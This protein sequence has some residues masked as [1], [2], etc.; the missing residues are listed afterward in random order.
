MPEKIQTLQGP[1]C[2]RLVSR[3]AEAASAA[4]FGET[5]TKLDKRRKDHSK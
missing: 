5:K 1:R 2:E 3:G 4:A